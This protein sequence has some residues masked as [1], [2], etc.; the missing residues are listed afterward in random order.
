MSAD[1]GLRTY[2]TVIADLQRASIPVRELT[3]AGNVAVT[4]AAGRV[5]AMAFSREAP[6]LFWSNPE[7]ADT[8]A[9]KAEPEKLVG[10]MGGDRL[11]FAPELAYHWKG[12]PDWQ[13]FSN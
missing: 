5:V 1:A 12:A 11:W 3:G 2:A 6:N 4:L 10:G 7:L 13:G 8:R 9:V